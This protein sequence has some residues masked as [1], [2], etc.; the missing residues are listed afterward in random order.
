[1]NLQKKTRRLFSVFENETGSLRLPTPCCTHKIS[2]IDRP[3]VN[4]VIPGS[5]LSFQFLI[6]WEKIQSKYFLFGKNKMC[7]FQRSLNNTV[8]FSLEKTGDESFL[9]KEKGEKSY[10]KKGKKNIIIFFSPRTVAECGL[11]EYC[12]KTAEI[13]AEAENLPGTVRGRVFLPSAASAVGGV[14]ENLGG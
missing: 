13:D 8:Y 5:F 14:A 11:Y 1:M 10:E 2:A 4:R 9:F 7:I 3:V 6:F 12:C